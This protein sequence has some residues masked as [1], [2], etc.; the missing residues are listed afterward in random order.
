[1]N[2]ECAAGRIV[3]AVTWSDGLR[4]TWPCPERATMRLGALPPE[5]LWLCHAHG[6]S[7]LRARDQWGAWHKT[8]KEFTEAMDATTKG[9]TTVSET[10]DELIERARQLPVAELVLRMLGRG[11]DVKDG[12]NIQDCFDCA[13]RVVWNQIPGIDEGS[14]RKP[15]DRN[16]VLTMVRR[17]PD[18]GIELTD[19]AKGVIDTGE[20]PRR[21]ALAL[22]QPQ[23]LRA[24]PLR[25]EA[26]E[27]DPY[28]PT[29]RVD[30]PITP[31]QFDYILGL[32]EE[33]AVVLVD[34]P[35]VIF[36][37]PNLYERLKRNAAKAD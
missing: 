11:H 33:G 36:A 29:H 22:E 17:T 18:G 15:L 20:K 10:F 14:P 21:P 23:V 9:G 12:H 25:P 7:M 13:V 37:P 1:M 4:W 32:V 27:V 28:A 3:L 5:P 31:E 2:R 8:L 35:G 16:D 19:E 24:S 34:P 26:G 6:M 30:G